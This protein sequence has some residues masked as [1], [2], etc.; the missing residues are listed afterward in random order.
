MAGYDRRYDKAYDIGYDKGYFVATIFLRHEVRHDTTDR[1]THNTVIVIDA[2]IAHCD[3]CSHQGKGHPMTNKRLPKRVEDKEDALLRR[4]FRW[5]RIH[6]SADELAR[7]EQQRKLYQKDVQTLSE[8]QRGEIANRCSLRRARNPFSQERQLAFAKAFWSIREIGE[9]LEA[10]GL[11]NVHQRL[12]ER[13]H[14]HTSILF[15][16]LQ[17]DDKAIFPHDT[18]EGIE[19]L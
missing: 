9:E 13:L 15:A 3:H 7:A 4:Q 11:L 8:L 1:C 19:N 17:P 14:L 2:D 6:D 12:A 10:T 16:L 18:D 5:S